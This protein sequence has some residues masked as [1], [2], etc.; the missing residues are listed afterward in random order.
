MANTIT[1]KKGLKTDLPTTGL[2]AGEPLFVTDDKLLYV[3]TA[4]N[5]SVNVGAEIDAS[6]SLGTSH[7]KLATQGAI[8][9]YIDSTAGGE[10]LSIK[11]AVSCASESNDDGFNAAPTFA[12]T[13]IT[14]TAAAKGAIA[15]ATGVFDTFAGTKA[16]DEPEVGDEITFSG[17]SG[18]GAIVTAV[19]G[20][21][22]ADVTCTFD[23]SITMADDVV[24]TFTAPVGVGQTLTD[25]ANTDVPVIDGVTITLGM[26]ILLKDQ[27]IG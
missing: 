22:G 12:T 3:A 1:F 5:A 27:N 14:C 4:S 2:A 24:C 17:G 7:I 26:R 11:Q 21:G 10:G 23:G 15:T 6:P 19:T 20:L 13:Q 25:G 9:E 18:S 16:V 8:K